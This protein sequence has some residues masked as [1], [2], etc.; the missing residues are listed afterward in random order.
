MTKLKNSKCDKTQKSKFYET[1]NVIQCKIQTV[2]NCNKSKT[3]N[4][5]EHKNPKCVKS[6]N[7]TKLKNS[8]YDQTQRLKMWQNSK[9]ERT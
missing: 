7:M 4:V 8:K 6:Q 9:Y 2:T 5:T 3:Q 1:Q